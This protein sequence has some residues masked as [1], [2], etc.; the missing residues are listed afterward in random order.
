MTLGDKL[1]RGK[2]HN[3]LDDSF[4]TATAFARRHTEALSWLKEEA[5]SEVLAIVTTTRAVVSRRDNLHKGA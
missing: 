5:P 3:M 2:A 4:V 1:S